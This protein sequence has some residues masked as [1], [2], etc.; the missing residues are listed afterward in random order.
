[1][2]SWNT[3][4]LSWKWRFHCITFL[5]SDV[6]HLNFNNKYRSYRKKIN[7]ETQRSIEITWRPRSKRYYY[8]F[9]VEAITPAYSAQKNWQNRFQMTAFSLKCHGWR[10]TRI[11]I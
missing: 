9:I 8:I 7:Q 6:N 11:W 10:K 5:A 1:M 3:Q 2:F 4:I